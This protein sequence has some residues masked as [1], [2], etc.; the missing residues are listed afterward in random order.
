MDH[1]VAAD[2]EDLCTF[3]ILYELYGDSLKGK[4]EETENQV[5]PYFKLGT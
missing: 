2:T 5:S 4:R 1:R 3:Y